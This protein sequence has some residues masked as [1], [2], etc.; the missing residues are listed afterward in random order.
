MVFRL[1]SSRRKTY[2]K[3]A[4]WLDSERVAQ[5][6]TAAAAA[7]A[8]T[9]HLKCRRGSAASLGNKINWIKHFLYRF[10]FNSFISIFSFALVAGL[11]NGKEAKC[12]ML[13]YDDL[14]VS[15]RSRLLQHFMQRRKHFKL[16]L[17]K[18]ENGGAWN[19]HSNLLI[20]FG[21]CQALSVSSP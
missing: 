7:E 10:A 4:T 15:T 12:R 8:H 16:N 11:S 3:S 19:V 18:K 20:K 5:W 6:Q 13:N 14:W 21:E 1:R 2:R 9:R 17:G